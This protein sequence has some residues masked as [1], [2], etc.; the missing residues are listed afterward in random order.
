MYNDGADIA[1]ALL[2]KKLFISG[3][4]GSNDTDN[5]AFNYSLCLL[6]VFGLFTEGYPVASLDHF[7]K[8]IGKGVKWHSTHGHLVFII[9]AAS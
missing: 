4:T 3:H 1:V 8:I 2:V 5:L 6:R 7:C 9:L